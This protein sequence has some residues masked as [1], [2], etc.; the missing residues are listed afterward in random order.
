MDALVTLA[1]ELLFAAVFVAAFVSYWRRRD[2][3]SRDVVLVFSAMAAIFA[4]DVLQFLIGTPP[5]T[6]SSA[7][8]VLLL[9]QP[10]FT[11]RLV[12][13]IRPVPR[14]VLVAAAV[15][16]LA[17][18]L[19]L[20]VL[21]SGTP[22]FV[23]LAAV[24]VFV[25]A[26]LVAA[27]FL[28][29]LARRRAGP[30]G[31]RLWIAAVATMLFA[32]AILAAG[33]GAAAGGAHPASEQAAQ[34]IALLAALGY[35]AAFIPPARLR[36]VWQ[37]QT[38]YR[39]LRALLATA[40]GEAPQIWSRLL[41]LAREATGAEAALLVVAD[42][43]GR[44]RIRA[45]D[46]L[47]PT[48]L[49]RPLDNWPASTPDGE[50]TIAA[51]M[52]GGLDGESSEL[53][54]A[55]GARFAQVIS[56]GSGA[57]APALILLA[58]QR[59]LFGQDDR[60]M[61]AALGA[62]A[63]RLVALRESLAE[64]GQLAD[65]LR[66]TVEAL[67]SA[68]QAKSDFLAAM[69]HELRTPLTAIL[70]FSDLMRREQ[71][72]G[73]ATI[74]VPLEW[75]EHIHRGGQHLVELVNDVLDLAKVEAGRLELAREPIEVHGIVTESVAGLRPLADRKGQTIEVVIPRGE[76]VLADRG[77][78]RQI[79]YNL[80]S[81]AIKFTP[82]GGTIRLEG[83]RRGEAFQLAVVDTGIGIAPDDQARVF[84]EFRQV[85][86]A[87]ER[88]Q[89][90][91]LGLA[92][93]RRLL[94]A[95]G[96]RIELESAVGVGSRFTIVLPATSAAGRTP[97]GPAS[98]ATA[99]REPDRPPAARS[100]LIV[101]DD[102]SAVRL[103][104]AYLEPE[105]YEVRVAS[106][107]ASALEDAQ[108][109]PP[110]AILLDVLLPGIDGWEVLRRLKADPALRDV[111][112]VMVTVVDERDVGLA[113]GA[114]DY[115]VKPIDRDALLASLARFTFSA[116]IRTRA[117]R[118]L[119]VDDE[120]AT[121]DF[122]EGVLRPDGYEVIRTADGSEALSLAKRHRPD[123]VICDLVM[124]G[125]DGFGVVAA[126]KEDPATS[127][128]PIVILTARDLSATDKERLNGKVL[129]ILSKGPD[130][131]EGLRDWLRRI[132]LAE[133]ADG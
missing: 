2:P 6:V 109:D 50:M 61:L 11:L 95:H 24:G 25:L 130:A 107:G 116:T 62:Q 132:G 79:L 104:R 67:R 21:G 49:G 51:L 127:A 76:F 83:E 22:T 108:R 38:A 56:L 14:V 29:A 98:A 77:R 133:A 23:T 20:A 88:S 47:G 18:S 112:V 53:A 31:V 87:A 28:A 102:P 64:Q 125:L 115:L 30:A 65:Q 120:P 92:L 36:G 52:V 9:G 42:G 131:R 1:I 10:F 13:Q 110:S 32:L 80:L 129:A 114:V 69:S 54:T 55:V 7:I 105:D 82:A 101:E 3:L 100:I 121:L 113:L 124:P 111:P 8:V 26:E 16:W 57:A 34:L 103:L 39:G 106:D 35:A 75:V 60:V 89:G 44:R 58:G 40:D 74:R 70:G 4:L 96:G 19:P 33:S 81:N 99:T 15:G 71:S 117:V 5:A 66:T 85:G 126:L 27:G 17:T 94:E 43:D 122:I 59:S 123:L 48:A 63:A 97:H 41:S 78:F 93:T 84:E 118:V 73:E 90:S 46:G 45:A 12:A 119:A 37:A 91:G 68:S 86:D 128:V 72:D